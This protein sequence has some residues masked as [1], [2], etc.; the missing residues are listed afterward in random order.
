MCVI[1]APRADI[2]PDAT[3]EEMD[4][5]NK[6]FTKLRRLEREYWNV[7]DGGVEDAEVG[8]PQEYSSSR[9]GYTLLVCFS[10]LC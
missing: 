10:Y 8:F 6:E 7:V 1:Q 5:I 3:E 4:E 9:S 2:P